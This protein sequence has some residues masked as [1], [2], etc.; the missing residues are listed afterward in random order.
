MA[1]KPDNLP[2]GCWIELSGSRLLLTNERAVFWP[3]PGK[4]TLILSDT[5]FGKAETFQEH[6]VPIPGKGTDHDLDRIRQ[7]ARQ[8]EVARIIFLGDLFHSHR[9]SSWDRVR[10]TLARLHRETELVLVMGNHDIIH[11]DHYESLGLACHGVLYDNPF[12][13]QHDPPA[14]PTTSPTAFSPVPKSAGSVSAEPSR[15]TGSLSGQDRASTHLTSGPLPAK[16]KQETNGEGHIICGHV[17]PSVRLR[18][19]AHQHLTLPCYWMRPD[20][21]VLPAF[22]SFT[23]SHTVEVGA[24]DKLWLITPENVIPHSQP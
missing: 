8:L 11:R 23:G 18:G 1:T 21:F 17:H 19:R 6:G 4:P 14:C 3:A 22:G 10:E 7:L 2:N 15:L 5:H 12:R 24:D 20:A 9:N 16:S 13:F